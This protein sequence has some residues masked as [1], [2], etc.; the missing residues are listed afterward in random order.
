[1]SVS[2]CQRAP[3]AS[4]GSERSQDLWRLPNPRLREGLCLHSSEN[5]A[6]GEPGHRKIVSPENRSAGGGLPSVYDALVLLPPAQQIRV[7]ARASQAD[8]GGGCAALEE[9]RVLKDHSRGTVWQRELFGRE[10]VIKCQKLDSPRRKLQSMLCAS[11]AWRHWKQARWLLAH[12]FSTAEPLAIVRGRRDGTAVE[13]LVL[14]YLSGRS[15]LEHLAGGGL[16]AGCEHRV[17]EAVAHLACRLA[18]ERRCNRDAKPSNLIVTSLHETGADLAVIDCADLRR[19]PPND[20]AAIVRM[21]VSAALEPM[22]CGCLPRRAVR[23]RAVF[24]AAEVLDPANPRTR[25]KR[26]WRLIERA[27]AAHGDPTPKDDPLA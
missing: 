23:M 4:E 18:R 24:T 27:V 8:W 12:G 14:E 11:P 7:V 19:C 15:V 13:C 10:C 22:G 2:I 20:E 5:R 9:G 16:S 21:L 26:L 1:M 3:R 25:A 6:A 17:A